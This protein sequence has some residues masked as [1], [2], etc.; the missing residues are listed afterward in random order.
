[1]PLSDGKTDGVGETL[2]KRT[3]GNLKTGSVVR[4]RMTGSDRVD[5]LR[6]SDQVLHADLFDFAY[7]EVLQVINADGVAEQMKK[8][9]LQHAAVTVTIRGIS[10]E[11]QTTG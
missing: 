1:M 4:L 9:I 7:T 2:A 6:P 10:F 8:S 5:L 3:G 11:N